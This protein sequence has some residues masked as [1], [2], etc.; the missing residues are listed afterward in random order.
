MQTDSSVR[1]V[2]RGDQKAS[3]QPRVWT[4][5]GLQRGI[6]HAVH[7]VPWPGYCV[8]EQLQPHVQVVIVSR[9]RSHMAFS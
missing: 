6:C 7:A 8:R 3:N 1:E 9:S 4:Y 2:L 5:V